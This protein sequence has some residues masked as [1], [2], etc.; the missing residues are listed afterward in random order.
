[1]SQCSSGCDE[2]TPELKLTDCTLTLSSLRRFKVIIL[3]N[4]KMCDPSAHGARCVMQQRQRAASV[5]RAR[6]S[7]FFLFFF[8]KPFLSFLLV[9]LPLSCA[10]TSLHISLCTVF[11]PHLSSEWTAQLVMSI[12]VLS[13]PLFRPLSAMSL[14][15][16][17]VRK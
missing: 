15:G 1:M 9:H 14:P 7:L 13:H 10:H 2:N 11:F 17:A 6:F 12:L 8:Y 16:A 3:H 5:P 4:P